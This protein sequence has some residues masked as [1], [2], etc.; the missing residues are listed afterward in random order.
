MRG[1]HLA[2]G[3]D[4]HVCA[5][6]LFQQLL[7]VD[8]IVTRNEDCGVVANADV[9]LRDL[10]CA[11]ARGVRR[12]QQRHGLHAIGTRLEHERGERIR[13]QRIVQRRR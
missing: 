11:V 1:Q 7:Q 9:H 13:R 12:V 10:R 3:I 4:I 2:V 8:Q 5:A 6:R